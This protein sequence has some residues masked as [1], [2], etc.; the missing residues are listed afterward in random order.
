MMVFFYFA[1]LFGAMF[2]V[3]TGGQDWNQV[4]TS[5]GECMYVMMRLA[6]FE[7]VGNPDLNVFELFV[8]MLIILK[9]L[10]SQTILP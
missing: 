5:L 6:F 4:C 2:Y 1:F 8:I 9:D 7:G 10:I 3:E